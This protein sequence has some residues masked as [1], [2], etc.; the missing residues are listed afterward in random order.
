MPDESQKSAYGGCA[1]RE[2]L[3]VVGIP[4]PPR[5]KSCCIGPSTLVVRLM[6]E[7]L[8]DAEVPGVWGEAPGPWCALPRRAWR[9]CR[10]RPGAGGF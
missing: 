1:V 6:T 5:N 3:E 7:I 8:Q 9:A 4:V 10:S 2:R